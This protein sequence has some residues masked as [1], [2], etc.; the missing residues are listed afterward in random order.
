MR[1]DSSKDKGRDERDVPLLAAPAPE[2]EVSESTDDL[3]A[4]AST[5]LGFWDNPYDDEDWND[6]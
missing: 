2:A 4:A 3:I 5:T 6:A 1:D